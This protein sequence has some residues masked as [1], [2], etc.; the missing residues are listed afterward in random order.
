MSHS[1]KQSLPLRQ[2]ESGKI[3]IIK[4]LNIVHNDRRRVCFCLN[5]VLNKFQFPL[6]KDKLIGEF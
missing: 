3:N 4:Y 1:R 2:L 5:L 6:C